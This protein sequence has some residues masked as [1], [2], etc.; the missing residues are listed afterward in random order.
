MRAARCRRP[1]QT[2][3]PIVGGSLQRIEF[4]LCLPIRVT[5]IRLELASVTQAPRGGS[6]F[7]PLNSAWETNALHL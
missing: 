7:K 2:I 6:T 4:D 5:L 1:D 3:D